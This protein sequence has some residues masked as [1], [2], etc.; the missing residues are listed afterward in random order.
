MR[1]REI[2][3]WADLCA[4][5]EDF[6]IG[7]WIFRGVPDRSYELVPV[8]GRQGARRSFEQIDLPFSEEGAKLLLETFKL[9]AR[10]MFPY[11]GDLDDLEWMALGRHHGLPTRLLDWT[12]SPL[13]AAYFACQAGGVLEGDSVTAAV[14][15]V[16]S[17]KVVKNAKE[18]SD[19]VDPVA[20]FPPH[21]SPR[22]TAQ[23]GLLT[24]H[25]K[26][27]EPWNP[28][29]LVKYVISPQTAI[30]IKV[31]LAKSGINAASM[32]PGLDGLAA[33]LAWQYKRQFLREITHSW[34]PEFEIAY[35]GRT[36][37]GQSVINA[38]Q[39]ITGV[40]ASGVAGSVTPSTKATPNDKP[41]S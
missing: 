22:I 36:A 40:A 41:S 28:A 31:A 12:T 15:A 23:Q 4:L 35:G 19:A 8:I 9:R 11:S 39:R 10:G 34:A 27:E 29:E 3:A 20:Y 38:M 2:K 7:K 33:D 26:P 32:M 21:V 14:Y 5:S 16:E 18:A 6:A 24:F 17:P 13:I 1:E 25:P 30:K 37:D